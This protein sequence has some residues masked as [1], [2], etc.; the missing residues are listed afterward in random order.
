M[1]TLKTGGKY[2]LASSHSITNDIPPEN[3]DAM[4]QALWDHGRY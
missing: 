4:L 1:S 3:F 2:I